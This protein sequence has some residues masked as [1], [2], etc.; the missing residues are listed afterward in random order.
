M[1]LCGNKVADALKFCRILSAKELGS[2]IKNNL[3]LSLIFVAHYQHSLPVPH[4]S[5]KFESYLGKMR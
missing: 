3:R 1:H 5:K 2:G 4:S